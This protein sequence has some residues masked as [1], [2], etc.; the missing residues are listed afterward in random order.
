[1]TYFY[2]IS[3]LYY[4]VL[5]LLYLFVTHSCFCSQTRTKCFH[6]KRLYDCPKALLDPYLA[7]SMK[8]NLITLEAQIKVLITIDFFHKCKISLKNTTFNFF[9]I[10]IMKNEVLDHKSHL[11]WRRPII[12]ST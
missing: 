1:M 5:N 9:K 12:Y 3:I 6:G 11:F 8:T 2:F 7:Y 10:L 4:S